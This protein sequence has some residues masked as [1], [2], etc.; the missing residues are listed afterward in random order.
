M[1]KEKT[2]TSLGAIAK[3][4]VISSTDLDR[5]QRNSERLEWIVKHVISTFWFEG[6]TDA[7]TDF[8][9]RVP[10]YRATNLVAAVDAAIAAEKGKT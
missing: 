9:V 8:G 2:R 3:Q 4:D 10:L 1:V 7:R 5:L 6:P